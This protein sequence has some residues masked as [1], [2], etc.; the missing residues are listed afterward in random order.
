LTGSIGLFHQS[1]PFFILSQSDNYKNAH[2]LTA[3]HYIV[4][5]NHLLTEDTK[6]SLEIYQKNYTYFPLNPDEPSLFAL[7]DIFSGMPY[8]FKSN[9]LTDNGR[10]L[11]RGGEVILQK[12]LAQDFYGMA[13][14]AVFSA[15]YQDLNGVWRDRV[16]NNRMLFSI[17]G[18]Y[19]PNS[20]WEFSV[21]WIYAGGTPYTPFDL[22][23]SR[24][25]DRAV[26]D[27]SKVNSLRQNDYHSLNVR[28]DKRFNFNSS[29]LV[30][31]LSIW[32][33][34]NRKNI[35]AR[36]WDEFK[37]EPAIQYQWSIMPII[38]VEYEY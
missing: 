8:F 7:D 15:R 2:D 30:L 20:E 37:N 10:A 21:R 5:A 13:S 26:L 32:N 6:L 38:G 19:K 14:A 11:A 23:A 9:N 35:A 3:V 34:Y 12:R 25:I 29:N 17:E 24:A 28:V 27:Q 16:F 1:L 22:A 33:A 4:G 18:G 36:Y 31:Y